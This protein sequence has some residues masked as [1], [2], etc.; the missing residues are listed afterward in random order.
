MGIWL[1]VKLGE[2]LFLG[3]LKADLFYF[4]SKI[5]FSEIFTFANKSS[6]LTLENIIALI[7][8]FENV[9]TKHGWMMCWGVFKCSVIQIPNLTPVEEYP[10]R[11]NDTA[12]E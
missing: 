8:F 10:F 4:F 2:R 7:I 3:F 6:Y 12:A 11:I 5:I 1:T 9:H